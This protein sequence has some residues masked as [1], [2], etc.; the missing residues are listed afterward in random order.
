MLSAKPSRDCERPRLG[1]TNS[2][3]KRV[4]WSSELGQVVP[5]QIEKNARTA[6]PATGQR[7]S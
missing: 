2:N 1:S 4:S 3:R 6:C 5:D 7:R